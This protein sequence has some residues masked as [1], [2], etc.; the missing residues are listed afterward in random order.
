MSGA[1]AQDKPLMVP[2]GMRAASID[3]LKWL[4]MA[5]MVIEHINKFVFKKRR[6]ACWLW[7]GWPCHYLVNKA[8]VVSTRLM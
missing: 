1:A 6:R 5:L 8:Y 2:F 4:A 7:A 3:A